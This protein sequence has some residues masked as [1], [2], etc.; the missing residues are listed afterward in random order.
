MFRWI[1]ERWYERMRRIDMEILWPACVR[2]APDLEHAKAA[3]ASHVF[4]DEAWLVL[5]HDQIVELIDTLG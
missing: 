4:H 2:Q 1:T 3:F 5:G